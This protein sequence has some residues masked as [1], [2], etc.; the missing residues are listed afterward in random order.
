VGGKAD[1]GRDLVIA[2]DYISHGL[3]ARS[4]HLATLELGPRSDL[5]IHRDLDAK[6]E[7]D[8]WTGLDRLLA[9]EADQHD[10]VI[11]LRRGG[12]GLARGH[13]WTAMIAHMRK[14]LRA[15]L[16]EPLGPARWRLSENGRAQHAGL[17]ERGDINQANPQGLT[18]QRIERSVTNF[19]FGHDRTAKP[20]IHR[21]VARGLD[22]KL[23][24][25]AYAVIDGV[26][27]RAH[28]I[29]LADLDAATDP[30]PGGIVELRRFQ[31]RSGRQRVALAMR[32]DCRSKPRSAQA[33]RP[34][35]DRQFVDSGKV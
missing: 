24:G 34:W 35:L 27:A 7:A 20:I 18:A 15:G 8:R 10:G 14:L 30:A 21:V 26:D 4:A 5:E 23:N 22:D 2:R 11:D 1:D 31:D 17:G 12:N 29:Q 32:P 9:R 19:I 13:M 3:R 6:G 16:A 28:H 25:T 33:G